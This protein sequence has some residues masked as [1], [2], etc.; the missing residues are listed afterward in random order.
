MKFYFYFFCFNPVKKLF[1]VLCT[2]LVHVYTE[3][4]QLLQNKLGEVFYNA[5]FCISSHNLNKKFIQIVRSYA[6]Y[7]NLIKIKNQTLNF[8][9]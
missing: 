1:Q 2:I 7:N 6:A 8:K 4:I 3:I 5:V 9:I